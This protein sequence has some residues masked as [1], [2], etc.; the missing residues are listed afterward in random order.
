LESPGPGA[1]RRKEIPGGS[2]EL[3]DQRAGG[4]TGADRIIATFRPPAGLKPGAY[5]LKVI[6]PG[7]PEAGGS[8]RFLVGPRV[9]G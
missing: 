9:R 1:G 7:A 8:L 4:A 3:I 6:V 2:L 5:V